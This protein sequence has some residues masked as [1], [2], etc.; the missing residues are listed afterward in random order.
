ML[1]PSKSLNS[2]GGKHEKL[3]G[4][5]SAHERL[6]FKGETSWDLR[7]KEGQKELELECMK[8]RWIRYRI[9]PFAEF[10]LCISIAYKELDLKSRV[11]YFH[12]VRNASHVQHLNAAQ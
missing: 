8:R 12:S 10:V 3:D 4:G 7:G 11:M 6:M 2:Q 1:R 5:K 9:G